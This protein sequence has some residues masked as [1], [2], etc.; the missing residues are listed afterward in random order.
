V[1]LKASSRSA[2]TITMPVT[3]DIT[4]PAAKL[5]ELYG[6]YR[7]HV[8]ESRNLNSDAGWREMHRQ[9]ASTLRHTYELLTGRDLDENAGVE[10]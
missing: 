10:R 8:T 7:R 1:T 2:D 5:E 6:R 4:I 3:C 9:D